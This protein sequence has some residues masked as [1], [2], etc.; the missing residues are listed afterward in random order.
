MLLT[1]FSV[2]AINDFNRCKAIQDVEACKD[3]CIEEMG[4][5]TGAANCVKACEKKG[6]E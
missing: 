2:W 4:S 6:N 1:S 3:C 5:S